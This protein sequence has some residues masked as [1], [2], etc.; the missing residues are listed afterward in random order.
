MSKEQDQAQETK[1]W[2]ELGVSQTLIDVLL[3]KGFKKPSLVQS[4]VDR[5][6][7]RSTRA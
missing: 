1:T 5:P 2:E 7:V 6:L 3:L 4:R